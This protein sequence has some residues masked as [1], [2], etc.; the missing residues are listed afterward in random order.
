MIIQKG[1]IIKFNGSWGSG[2]GNLSIKTDKG[3]KNIP[4]E[5]PSTV[6]ALESAFGDVITAGHTADGNGYKDQEIYFSVADYGVLEGFVPVEEASFQLIE[7]YEKQK[8]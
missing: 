3:I 4:C 5:N 1:K 6:R 8:E 7:E 2:L